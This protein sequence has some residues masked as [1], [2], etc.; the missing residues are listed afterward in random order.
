MP[1]KKKNPPPPNLSAQQM[2][3]LRMDE[4]TFL[5]FCQG[6]V[7]IGIGSGSFNGAMFDVLCWTRM[8]ERAPN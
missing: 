2:E 8:R 5:N 6:H 1:R 7:L 4:T 3:V